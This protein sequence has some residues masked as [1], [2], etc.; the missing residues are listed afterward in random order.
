MPAGCLAVSSCPAA[1][2]E[3]AEAHELSHE[4]TSWL[5]ATRTGKHRA[6][7]SGAWQIIAQ[8]LPHRTVQA[9]YAMGSRMFHEG[10]YK[11]RLSAQLSA[12]VNLLQGSLEQCCA[13]PI[14]CCR[15]QRLFAVAVSLQP[16]CAW[17]PASLYPQECPRLQGAWQPE[18]DQHLI[19][20]VAERGRRW[21]EIGQIIGRMGGTWLGVSVDVQ[22]LANALASAPG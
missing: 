13:Q 19:Q 6:Q 3:Y 15:M 22:W 2:Q 20:L 16:P 10:N 4:D 8:A 1:V 14:G 21:K 9:V 17:Y 18:E 12:T 5:Y 7:A 11:A